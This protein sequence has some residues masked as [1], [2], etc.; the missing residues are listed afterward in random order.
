MHD[1]DC[2]CDSQNAVQIVAARIEQLEAKLA[3]AMEALNA[4]KAYESS[5][6]FGPDAEKHKRAAYRGM[7]RKLLAA[8]T[9]IEA[10]P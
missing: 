7:K 9:K 10:K 5:A 6:F 3:L 4:F 8:L 2:N 1:P